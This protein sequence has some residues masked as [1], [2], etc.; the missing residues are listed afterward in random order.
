MVSDI[1]ENI[2][3]IPKPSQLTMLES[4][5][6]LNTDTVIVADA[7]AHTEAEKLARGL[8]VVTGFA[9]PVQEGA[10]H[11]SIRLSLDAALESLGAEGYE[12]EVTRDGAN[13][14]ARTEAGLFYAAQTL[15]Q[16]LPPAA[17]GKTRADEVTWEARGVRVRDVP[18]FAWRG[19]H[20]DCSRHFMPV[21]FI[22]KLLEAMALH[23]LN[24]F[25]WHLTDDQGWRLEIKK[26]PRLTEVG[27][28]R[29]G[30]RVGHEYGGTGYDDAVHSGGNQGEFDDVR[31]GGFYT[32]AEARDIVAFAKALH[33]EVVPEIELPGHAQ[34]AIAAYPELGNTN[35]TLEVCRH[36]GIIK[37]VYNPSER[38]LEFLE[39]VFSEVLEVFPG[40]YIHVGG[41]E[42]PK[43]EWKASE[44]AQMRIE[45]L[46]LKDEEE[47]QSHFIRRMDA[48]LHAR[49]RRLIGWDEILE[50]G[51]SPNATVH[52]WRGEQ[53]GIQAAKA[54]HDVV[55]APFTPTYL[56]Y[57]QSADT[58]KEPQAIGGCNTLESL[59]AYEPIPAELTDL[60][61]RHVLGSQV[62]LWT[63]YVSTPE[64]AA[65]MYFPR[66]SAF[67]EVVWSAK[68]KRD[69]PEFL[70]RLEPHLTRLQ[71]LE[72]NFRALD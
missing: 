27:A 65:Y 64:H 56:D 55:M 47:L 63:E 28:W 33:I 34:A 6:I 4:S 12:L 7:A 39:D 10:A 71:A 70:T 30:T 41:D 9:L 61:A 60:E 13:L 5:F 19:L 46:G 58:S 22:K 67:S 59:Y 52:S 40:T 66:T 26:Y 14:R 8:R 69:Y 42:C 11:N 31:H 15:R 50:G 35:E 62:Q 18:R 3:I 17:F 44:F 38:T 16:L 37:H 57:Y 68:E 49:G 2:V 72:V 36:W 24:T 25:H 43:D 51:L 20:L 23:K 48:F 21:T 32:Q 29:N 1:L 53:G 54:G 45:E